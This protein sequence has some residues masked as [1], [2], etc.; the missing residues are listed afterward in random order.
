[1][2]G[3]ITPHRGQKDAWRLRVYLGKDPVTGK[4]RYRSSVFRGKKGDAEAALMTMV[5]KA[6]SEKQVSTSITVAALMNE[7][8]KYLRRIGRSHTTIYGYE[9]RIRKHLLPAIGDISLEDLTAKHLDDLYSQLLENSAPATVRQTHAIIRKSLDQARRWG[10]LDRNVAELATAPKVGRSEIAVPSVGELR[11]LIE[12]AKKINPQLSSLIA[13]AAVTGA[14]RGEL[15]GLRLADINL[16]Q[17]YV[18]IRGSLS[19]SGREG[20][21][22]GPTKTHQTRR[23]ALDEFG[24]SVVMRQI[25]L[26]REG[27]SKLEIEPVED[28]WLFFREVDGSVPLFPDTVSSAFAR[29]SKKLGIKGIR[30][31]SLRHFTAT[32]LIAAGVDIRTVSGRLGHSEPS[33][34]LRVYSHVLEENDRFASGIVGNLLAK[35][36][37]NAESGNLKDLSK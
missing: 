15:L 17:G 3:S 37:S 2:R 25:D 35:K 26:L 31:H 4:D 20:V 13:L 10:W 32:Q 33:I 1:M 34:T 29:L 14:R 7:W 30:F 23:V 11:T 27:C 21:K 12:E 19:Y 9:W 5:T 22:Y 24:L 6:Q 28:P 16:E 8:M 18:V 36:E